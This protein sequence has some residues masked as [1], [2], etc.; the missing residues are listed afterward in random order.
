V[1]RP[2]DLTPEECALWHQATRHDTKF[3][4]SNGQEIIYA[5]PE[6]EAEQ[7][8]AIAAPLKPQR[9]AAQ[10]T[11][12]VGEIHMMDGLNARRFKRG[13][14]Q[15]DCALDLHGYGRVE[16]FDALERTIRSMVARGERV[17]AVIT[18]KGRGGDGVLK[19]EMPHW[20]NDTAIRKHVVAATH[21]PHRLGGEGAVLVMLKRTRDL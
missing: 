20:L 14:L 16:A 19:R 17:L 12:V 13:E 3:H 10:P 15:V 2:R 21:A 4:A 11:I 8:V 7:E 5:E 6:R 1:A 18:G 9:K